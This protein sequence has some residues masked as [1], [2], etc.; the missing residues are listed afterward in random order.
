MS[1]SFGDFAL[2]LIVRQ[3][4]FGTLSTG[5]ITAGVPPSHNASS[6]RFHMFYMAHVSP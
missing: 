5:L 4:L 6:G 3:L 1:D 2:G